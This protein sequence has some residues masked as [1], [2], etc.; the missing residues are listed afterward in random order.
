MVAIAFTCWTTYL[1]FWISAGDTI[2]CGWI[3]NHQTEIVVVAKCWTGTLRTT[4]RRTLTAIASVLIYK[5][6][7]Y[8]F[9]ILTGRTI[10]CRGIWQAECII[11]ALRRTSASPRQAIDSVA[12]IAH[13]SWGR[14]ARQAFWI[15][16]GLRRRGSCYF[17]FCC[18]YY[19]YY[20]YYEHRFEKQSR[21]MEYKDRS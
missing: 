15:E 13:R 19:Y 9:G 18:Y 17:I 14:R 10:E 3:V 12:D 16:A 7:R 21:G 1:T 8:A 5:S 20:Y 6:A 11:V 4:A 2:I